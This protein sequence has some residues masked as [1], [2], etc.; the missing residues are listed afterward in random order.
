MILGFNLIGFLIIIL[1][2][3]LYAWILYLSS[4]YKSLN[5]KNSTHFFIGGIFSIILLNFISFFFPY[6]N[7]YYF[8][9]PF[10]QSFWAVAPKEELSKFLMF[11]IIYKGM[12]SESKT[13]PITYMVYLGMVGLGFAF[14]ENI[15]YVA[16]YGFEVLIIRNLGPVFVHMICGLLLG[17][18]VGIRKIKKQP[19]QKTISSNYLNSKPKIKSLIYI[20]MGLISASIFHGLWNYHLFI[21]GISSK[22]ISILILII[23]FLSCKLLFKDLINQ[24]QQSI[25][26]ESLESRIDKDLEKI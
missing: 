18:W 24:Y 16:K 9:D 5:V 19:L 8:L 23:G 22:P 26:Y 20:T 7:F 12:D 4:P 10:W 15:Q 21:F 25:T 14:I 6:W 11:L 17:Y 13:H 3:L 2:P 1:P